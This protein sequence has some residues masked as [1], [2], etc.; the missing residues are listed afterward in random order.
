MRSMEEEDLTGRAEVDMWR[1]SVF[2]RASEVV[3]GWTDVLKRGC[4]GD[5][6]SRFSILNQLELME[7]FVGEA[8]EERVTAL[9]KVVHELLTN[10]DSN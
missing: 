7:G 8:K 4:F 5:K 10:M 1:R 2:D 6:T 3:V 9:T